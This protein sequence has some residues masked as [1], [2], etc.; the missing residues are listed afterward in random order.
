MVDVAV[1]LGADRDI[2]TAQ[3]FDTLQFEI[4]LANVSI[5][6]TV[7]PAA[8]IFNSLIFFSI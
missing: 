1:Y 3:L 8:I 5:L 4:A 6:Q 2:A 7:Q